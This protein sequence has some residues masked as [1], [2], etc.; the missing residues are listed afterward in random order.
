MSY[1]FVN[2]SENIIKILKIGFVTGLGTGFIPVAP[3]TFA[4]LIS[5]VIWF[6]LIDFVYIYW[7]VLANLLVWGLIIS[8]EW[9]KVWCKD[10]RK[11]V[12][13]EYA[14]LLLS[15]YFVPK[16]IISLVFAFILFRILDAVKPPPLRQLEKL[17]GA[18]GIMLDDLGAAIYTLFVFK[19]LKFFFEP[20][21]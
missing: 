7:A 6:F 4:C 10:P 16:K 18:W 15:L 20:L 19:I 3:A 1:R 9:R 2:V 17:P 12:I 13:D 8:H 21:F 11:I 14:A 5:V